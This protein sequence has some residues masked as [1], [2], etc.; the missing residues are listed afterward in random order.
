MLLLPSEE[1][2]L[3]VIGGIDVEWRFDQGELEL[4]LSL[5]EFVL[6]F[7]G[8]VERHFAGQEVVLEGSSFVE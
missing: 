8:E 6:V 3:V 1:E 2:V 4:F 5:V 7:L